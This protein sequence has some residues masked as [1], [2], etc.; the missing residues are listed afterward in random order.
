[1][2]GET[3]A[4]DKWPYQCPG[5]GAALLIDAPINI[6][7]RWPEILARYGFNAVAMG[8]GWEKFGKRPVNPVWKPA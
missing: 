1:V 8:G 7:A 2:E 5:C 6:L 4:A 3:N